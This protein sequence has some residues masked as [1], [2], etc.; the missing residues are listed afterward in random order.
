MF[1]KFIQIIICYYL[2]IIIH[3]C[4]HYFVLTKINKQKG[5]LSI[6]CQKLLFQ[7]KNI[8]IR[9]NP[10]QSSVMHLENPKNEKLYYISGT[11]GNLILGL[12]GFV[13]FPQ[14]DWFYK[15][16]FCVVLGNL[17]LI[18]PQTD[19]YKTFN[20]DRIIKFKN[21]ENEWLMGLW[22][23]IYQFIVVPIFF[24]LIIWKIFF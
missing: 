23:L 21:S 17:L 14:F 9:L 11:I 15:Y 19:I 16:S 13:I 20:T 22:C 1:I 5:I 7:Y 10:L 24:I 12:I 2:N 8:Q 18:A 4:S 6:G 3:E